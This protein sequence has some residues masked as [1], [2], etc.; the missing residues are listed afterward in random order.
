MRGKHLWLITVAGQDD[1]L[2]FVTDYRSETAAIQ[3]ANAFIRKN[4]GPT[5]R[6]SNIEY[7]GTIDA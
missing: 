3:K 1:T 2:K 6:I 7:S 5:Y 4:I